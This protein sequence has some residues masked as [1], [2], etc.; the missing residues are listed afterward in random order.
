MKNEIVGELALVTGAG[1][2]IG[3]A[4]AVRLAQLGCDVVLVGRTVSKL[5]ATAAEV[6]AT[7]REAFPMACD[8]T[9]ADAI[10]R[11]VADVEREHGRLDV[12]VNNAGVL[13]SKRLEDTTTD[14]LDAI[15]KTNVR[16]PYILCREALRLLRKSKAAEIVNICSVVAHTGYPLQSAYAASKHALLGMS[17]SLSREVYEEGIRVHVISPGGVLTEMIGEARPDL[18]GTPMIV[19]DDI[20]DAVEFFLTHRTDG[21][22]DE[23]RLHRSTKAPF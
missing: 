4:I 6:R 16:A 18:V 19:P 15:L 14:E 17:E 5:K 11:L 21:V 20:A 23:I 7:G 8:L 10:E 3:K 9:D 13:V 12:L 1:T 22:V 2:G